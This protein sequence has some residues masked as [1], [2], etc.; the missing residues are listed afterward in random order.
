MFF[1]SIISYSAAITKQSPV[2][3]I[4][5][6]DLPVSVKSQ[7]D[8]SYTTYI[9]TAYI[10]Y[11]Q[12]AGA[13]VVPIFGYSSHEDLAELLPKINGVLFPGGE[14]DFNMDHRWTSNANYILKYAMEETDKGNPFPVWGTCLGF[15]LLAY[16]TG[17]YD[18]KVLSKVHGQIMVHRPL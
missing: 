11:I 13:Q 3:G 12:M 8:P 16:L 10:K 7:I 2:I 1:G 18:N 5:T 9:S 15:Q 6:Q 14:I 4:Y 17:G